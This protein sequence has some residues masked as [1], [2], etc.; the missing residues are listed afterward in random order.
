MYE[1][2]FDDSIIIMIWLNETNYQFYVN[3]MLMKSE[4]EYFLEYIKGKQAT[5]PKV[6]ACGN[7]P[8]AIMR[9][10]HAV[11]ISFMKNNYAIFIW[12]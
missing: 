11:I 9:N 8:D 6:F 12:F 10:W 2:I 3:K 1:F 4:I 5:V 7:S